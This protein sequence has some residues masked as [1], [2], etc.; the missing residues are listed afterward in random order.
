MFP[1]H[2][3]DLSQSLHVDFAEPA[4]VIGTDV[5]REQVAEPDRPKADYPWFWGDE[6]TED[7]A[8]G[9]TFDGNRWN[10]CH[11]TNK[12][13]QAAREAAEKKG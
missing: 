4:C 3:A 9:K 12:V 1:N 6:K 5:E 13:K 2:L 7:F 8:G 11:Y 10:D